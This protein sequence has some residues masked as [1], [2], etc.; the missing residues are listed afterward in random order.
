[1]RIAVMLAASVLVAGCSQ[2]VEEQARQTEPTLSAPSVTTR[3]SPTPTTT[4]TKPPPT[5]APAAGAP[6]GEV[7]RWIEAAPPAAPEGFRTVSREG[8]A[9]DLGDGVAFTTPAGTSKCVTDRRAEGALTC[10]VDLTEPPAR[11]PDVYG[12]WK[13]GWV[14][15]PGATLDVGSAH[16]DP[17]PF[18]DGFGVELPYGQALNFGDYRCRT[19]PSGLFCV[20]YAHQSAARLSDTGV[21]PF[22]CLQQVTPPPGVGARF[23][24]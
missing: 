13:G 15:F 20:N 12:E 3:T 19:D 10:L 23:S 14:D 21:E 6:I 24:C 11:P 22:G 7:V 2:G 1:M 17:G 16:A 8:A 9:T 5:S 4:T 18:S